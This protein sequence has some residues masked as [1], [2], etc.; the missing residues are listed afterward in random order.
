MTGPVLAVRE[1]CEA[2]CDRVHR[3]HVWGARWDVQRCKI[4]D[5][6]L[7]AYRLGTNPSR[8]GIGGRRKWRPLSPGSAD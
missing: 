8:K 7:H 5:C 2:K 3:E 1:F 4:T 6:P